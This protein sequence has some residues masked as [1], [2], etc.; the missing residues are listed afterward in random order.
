MGVKRTSQRA[1]G[2]S[3]YSYEYI[4]KCF[5]A[6]RGPK[7]DLSEAQCDRYGDWMAVKNVAIDWLMGHGKELAATVGSV[8]TN[9]NQ[10]DPGMIIA[11]LSKKG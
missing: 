3:E 9:P 4:I 10:V 2:R 8:I 6:H 7:L 1:P 11:G 5:G